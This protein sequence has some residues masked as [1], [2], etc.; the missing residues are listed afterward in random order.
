MTI[1]CQMNGIYKSFKEY[2]LTNDDLD[3]KCCLT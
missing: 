1:K 2:F 3:I